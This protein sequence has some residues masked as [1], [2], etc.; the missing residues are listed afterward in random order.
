M[1]TDESFGIE[2][3]SAAGVKG[4]LPSASVAPLQVS[5]TEALATML[6]RSFRNEPNFVYIMPD[7]QARQM[8]L[9]SFFQMAA[10]PASRVFGVICTTNQIDG[11]SLWIRDGSGFTFE[12]MIRDAMRGM[13]LKLDQASLRRWVNLG[14]QVEKARHRLVR[15]PHWYLLALGVEPSIDR[16]ALSGLLTEPVLSR[17]DS[18]KIPCYVEIFDE[19]DLSFYENLGFRVEGAGGIPHGGPS[20]WAMIRAPK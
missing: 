16:C 19:R 14:A 9:L 8:T 3:H 15:G 1:S 17:A 20:F 11:A 12:R 10:I 5:Q 13:P 6:S 4:T 2:M 7:E 18:D